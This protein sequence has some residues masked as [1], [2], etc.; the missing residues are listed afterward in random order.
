[1][2]HLPVKRIY[3][4]KT[5]WS[6]PL[7]MKM[8]FLLSSLI[9]ACTAAIAA[10]IDKKVSRKKIIGAWVDGLAANHN[11]VEMQALRPQLERF[12]DL[13]RSVHWGNVIQICY[14]PSIGTEARINDER[15]GTV[16]GD[17][18]FHALLKIWLGSHPAGADL[19]TAM[20]GLD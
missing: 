7:F 12:N 10:S 5:G 3:C 1:M 2:N 9:L 8:L 11:A 18:F 6:G 20:L 13:F 19:K 17:P 4:C 14:L 16:P 15:R